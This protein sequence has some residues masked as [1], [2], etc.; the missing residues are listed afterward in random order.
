[1]N[2]EIT[3]CVMWNYKPEAARLADELKQ[4]LDITPKLTEGSKGIFDVKK[5][6]ELVYSKHETGRFP[7]EGEVTKILKG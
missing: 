1:M 3:Y 5:D 6:G 2:V 7:N 4:N